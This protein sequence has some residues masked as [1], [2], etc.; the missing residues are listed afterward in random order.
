MISIIK[1]EAKYAAV[2]KQLNLEWLDKYGLT[3]EAILQ[4]SMI[5][6]EKL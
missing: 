5:L 1:Y 3:E 6:K 2:F 4:C